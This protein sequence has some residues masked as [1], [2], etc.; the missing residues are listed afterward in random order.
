MNTTLISK[1]EFEVKIGEHYR[2]RLTNVEVMAIEAERV[3]L[4]S[5]DSNKNIFFQSHTRLLVDNRKGYFQKIQEAPFLGE[6]CNVIGALSDQARKKLNRKLTYIEACLERLGGSLAV[7]KTQ[8]VLQEIAS[9]INDK[10]KPSYSSLYKWTRTY[11]T[12][13]RNPISLLPQKVRSRQLRIERQPEV[14]Q[15]LIRYCCDLLFFCP[16]PC[17]ISATVEAIEYSIV[18]ANK[19]RPIFDQ[20]SCPSKSTLRRIIQE[21]DTFETD[22]HQLGRS[23][24]YRNQHWSRK[25]PELR[26]L[27]LRVECDTQLL[28]LY[29]V[30]KYGNPIGRP[31]LTI[32]LEDASRRVIG[33]DLSLNP[34]SIEK[35]IRA[36]KSSLSSANERNGLALFYITDNG[37]EFIADKLKSCLQ[38]MG[39]H[40][41][42]CE[43]GAPNQKPFVERWFHTLNTALIHHIKGTTFSSIID[44]GPYDSEKEAT[45]TLDEVRSII[46][47]WLDTIYHIDRHSSLRT[48]PNRF[49]DSHISNIFPPIRYSENDLKR[50]FLS[51]KYVTPNN[52]RVGF[53]GLEWSGPSVKYLATLNQNHG[54]NKRHH[55]SNKLILLYDPSDLGIAYI[56]HPSTPDDVHT[57]TATSEYQKD[58]TLHMHELIRDEIKNQEKDFNYEIARDNRARLNLKL[59][60]E[61]AKKRK[62][63]RIARLYEEGSVPSEP[64]DTVLN[65]EAPQ[66]DFVIDPNRHLLQSKTPQRPIT[67]EVKHKL[68]QGDPHEHSN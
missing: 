53:L 37:S 32:A 39:A 65:P 54:R 14:I 57:V 23:A 42:F 38:L 20:I 51:M 5:L 22:S 61:Y 63:K 30:D 12:S 31:W 36:I 55:R 2:Y 58:L 6:A 29:V 50:I 8:A 33:W 41:T 62:V 67:I 44:K 52:S 43:P 45:H 16:T 35:T 18:D 9:T 13:G 56:A 19:G 17:T 68:S 27:L 11:L 24:A 3:Q 48:S 47:N 26:S 4:R 49:W 15:A 34:P 7:E 25:F 28:D 10:R 59:A 64:Q 40:I 21:L 1:P 60:E 46:G 66:T